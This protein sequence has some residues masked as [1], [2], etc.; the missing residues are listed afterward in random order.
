[1][2]TETQRGSDKYYCMGRYKGCKFPN[3]T[4]KEGDLVIVGDYRDNLDMCVRCKATYQE[5]VKEQKE[6]MGKEQKGGGRRGKRRKSK[7]RKSIYKGERITKK[8]TTKKRTTKKRKTKKRK[9]KK[10]KN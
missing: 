2:A 7:N 4:Y 8:R 5:Q 10:R 1:M 9:T 6:K 3:G